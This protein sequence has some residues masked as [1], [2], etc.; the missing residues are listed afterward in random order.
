M[1]Q[2]LR[3]KSTKVFQ[4]KDPSAPSRSKEEIR[5]KCTSVVGTGSQSVRSEVD[6]KDVHTILPEGQ[7]EAAAHEGALTPHVE[8]NDNGKEASRAFETAGEPRPPNKIPDRPLLPPP[9]MRWKLGVKLRGLLS[10]TPKRDKGIRKR[11]ERV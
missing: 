2:G 10:H 7:T 1:K 8:G 5:A 11:E 4:R 6:D 3:A 9:K